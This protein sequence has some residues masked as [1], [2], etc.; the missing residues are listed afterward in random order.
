MFLILQS[1]VVN[2]EKFL[3][4]TPIDETTPLED[5]GGNY[6][7]EARTENLVLCSNLPASHHH[8]KIQSQP[9]I[10]TKTIP[11]EA[12]PMLASNRLSML[13]NSERL[14]LPGRSRKHGCVDKPSLLYDPV[15]VSVPKNEIITQTTCQPRL[16]KV[17]VYTKAVNPYIVIYDSSKKYAKPSAYLKLVN[18]T[19]KTGNVYDKTKDDDNNND[20]DCMFTILPSKIEE[21][22]N[23]SPILLQASNVEKRNEWVQFLTEVCN[24]KGTRADSTTGY[25]PGSSVLP[26]LVEQ[27]DNDDE[28][29]KP[30]DSMKSPSRRKNREGRRSSLNSLGIRLRCYTIGSVGSGRWTPYFSYLFVCCLFFVIFFYC[31]TSYLIAHCAVTIAILIDAVAFFSFTCNENLNSCCECKQHSDWFWRQGGL[32]I[33]SQTNTFSCE[34]FHSKHRLRWV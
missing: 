3:N 23:I 27:D 1:C 32:N 17:S 8:H 30:I 18:C 2:I 11:T 25:V 9:Q 16:V 33:I 24:G 15:A 28:T 12:R 29:K 14:N 19:V 26:T 7:G 5:Q 20:D 21:A 4:M 10:I 6:S 13:R 31:K 22:D 34:I